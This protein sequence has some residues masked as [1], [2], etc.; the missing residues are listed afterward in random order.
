MRSR[1]LLL[2]LILL[3]VFLLTGCPQPRTPNDSTSLTMKEPSGRAREVKRILH[4]M[5]QTCEDIQT[6]KAYIKLVYKDKEDRFKCNI[7]IVYKK[8]AGLRLKATKMGA[9]GFELL[10]IGDDFW[11]Y[12]AREKTTEKGSCRELA[13][14]H[15]LLGLAN[16]LHDV[17]ADL[18]GKIAPPSKTSAPHLIMDSPQKHLVACRHK[19]RNIYLWL[20]KS[21]HVILQKKVFDTRGRF[22]YL[23]KFSRFDK[24]N[25][26]LIPKKYYYFLQNP[27]REI[28]FFTV[29]RKINTPVSEKEFIPEFK[30]DFKN[31][32]ED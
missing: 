2:P 20:E 13:R 12:N 27:D 11:F 25:D 8:D 23:S 24:R 17:I 26:H 16:I 30:H 15:S 21:P 1:I 5:N 4:G 32:R 19:D 7:S 9:P 6:L 29:R 14:D 10:I 3:P 31:P 22:L 18:G 28:T